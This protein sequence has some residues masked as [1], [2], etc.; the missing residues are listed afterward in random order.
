M[1]AR[2]RSDTSEANVA[3]GMAMADVA[4]GLTERYFTTSRAL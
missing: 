4:R 1:I 2:K 3:R